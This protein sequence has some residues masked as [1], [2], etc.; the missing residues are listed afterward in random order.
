MKLIARQKAKDAIRSNSKQ[1]SCRGGGAAFMATWAKG[2]PWE[3]VIID[4]ME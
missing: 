1:L 4:L 2:F 3:H